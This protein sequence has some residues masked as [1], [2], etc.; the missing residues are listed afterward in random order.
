[1]QKK[2]CLDYLRHLIHVYGGDSKVTYII[3]HLRLAA[4]ITR[5]G[6]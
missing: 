4:A 5:G 2:L 3:S 6:R 1:M